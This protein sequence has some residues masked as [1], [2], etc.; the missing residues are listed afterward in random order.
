MDCKQFQY[1]PL[2]TLCHLASLATCRA[3]SEATGLQVASAEGSKSGGEWAWLLSTLGHV[4][5]CTAF[6][7]D[8]YRVYRSCETDAVRRSAARPFV[9]DAQSAVRLPESRSR[10]R[11]DRLSAV[12]WHFARLDKHDSDLLTHAVHSPPCPNLYIEHN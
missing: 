8:H 3:G 9:R 10:L 6:V 1:A 2:P 5:G 4:A 12:A 11:L 7:S